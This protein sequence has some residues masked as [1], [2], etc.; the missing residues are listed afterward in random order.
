MPFVWAKD[1]DYGAHIPELENLT[2]IEPVTGKTY[3][4]IFRYDTVDCIG[5]PDK[6]DGHDKEQINYTDGLY[7]GQRWFIKNNIKPTFYFGHGLSYTTFEFSDLTTSINNDGLTAEF[8]IKNTGSIVGKAVAMMFLDF[9]DSIGDYPKNIF[10]G[11]EK[12]EIQPGETASVKILAD[13]HALSYFNVNENKYV[14]VKGNIKVYI[15]DNA[16]PSK[17]K[18]NGEVNAS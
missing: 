15:S 13:D 11:F 4:D 1:E 5:N 14:R 3:K 10:K 8:K 9:P 17:Y 16:D 7:I 2:V 18:L 12:V 6:E